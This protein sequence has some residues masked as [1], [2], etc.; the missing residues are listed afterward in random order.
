MPCI[1]ESWVEGAFLY[2]ITP[3][4]TNATVLLNSLANHLHQVKFSV[5]AVASTVKQELLFAKNNIRN[6]DYSK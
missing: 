4:N 3:T 2:A 1:T 6:E 5:E